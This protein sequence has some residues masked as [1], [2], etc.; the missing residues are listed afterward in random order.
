MFIAA[1]VGVATKLA[2]GG[3]MPGTFENRLAA[4]PDVALGAPLGALVVSRIG[5]RPTL[6]IVSVLCVLVFQRIYVYGR[7]LARRDQG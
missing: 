7:R 5:R 2:T 6:L 3:L 1:L 4:A